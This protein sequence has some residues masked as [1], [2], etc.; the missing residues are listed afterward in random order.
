MISFASSSYRKTPN[1]GGGG[2]G[3]ITFLYL[4]MM[5]IS[6]GKEGQALNCSITQHSKIPF[7]AKVARKK[8][9][10]SPAVNLVSNILLVH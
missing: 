9:L 8:Q 2:V 6:S 5:Q 7:F 4:M 3:C 1:L 10:I